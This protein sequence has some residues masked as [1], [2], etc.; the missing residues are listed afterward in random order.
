[1]MASMDECSF[2]GVPIEDTWEPEILIDDPFSEESSTLSEEDNFDD[3][4]MLVDD[5]DKECPST[6]QTVEHDMFDLNEVQ[7]HP[8]TPEYSLKPTYQRALPPMVSPGVWENATDS[9]VA[10][11]CDELYEETLTKL[12]NSM[13]RSE[14]TRKHIIHQR[15]LVGD[16]SMT[17][18][19]DESRSR[20][21]SFI[22][23]HQHT[24]N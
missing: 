11:S 7:V 23:A 19:T 20:M 18:Y 17:E 8:I 13:R 5:L 3:F 9:T 6:S 21:W 10:P 12:A 2:A 16:H 15:Q 24:R 1:M 14:L 22:E 4:Q